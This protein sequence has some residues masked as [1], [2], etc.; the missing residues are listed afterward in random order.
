M[1][2]TAQHIIVFAAVNIAIFVTL[3]FFLSFVNKAMNRKKNK[4]NPN[5]SEINDKKKEQI[6]AHIQKV[7]TEEMKKRQAEIETKVRAEYQSKI[8][9]KDDEIIEIT[10]HLKSEKQAREQLVVEKKKTE[11]V[12]HSIAAGVIVVNDKGETVMMNPAA[13]KILGKNQSE[14]LGKPVI[15][16]KG[17]GQMIS[18]AGSEED[19]KIIL[20]EDEDKTSK[21]LRSS[22]AVIENEKGQ[23]VGMVS[24]ISDKTKQKELEETKTRFVASV[25]H[26]LRTPLTA[27]QRSLEIIV[28]GQLGEVS[29]KQ[30]E[31]L[32]M[33]LSSIQRLR[34]L[35]NDILDFSK[36]DS[37]RME[38][39]CEML[40]VENLAKEVK[41]AFHILVKDKNVKL[42][43]DLDDPEMRIE[44]DFNRLIQVLTNLIANALKYT[45]EGGQITLKV[46]GVKDAQGDVQRVLFEIIDTGCGISQEDQKNIFEQFA[47]GSQ[48]TEE[49]F[50]GTGLGLTIAKQ[51]VELHRG[52]IAVKSELGKGSTFYFEI[53]RHQQTHH[54]EDAA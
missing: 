52:E 35:V 32:G 46:S 28:A 12:I 26:E 47:Q 17:E 3:Y 34:S 37:G 22:S 50:R 25:S 6:Q 43:L 54:E 1:D 15:Q 48:S 11:N 7:L 39:S 38:I 16:T 44:G 21:T 49:K 2:L 23:T 8:K 14:A 41:K 27:I 5:A 31:F 9:E 20:S 45:P 42:V 13:E 51:I 24:I 18:I 19:G 4:L 53:P 33:S 29:E 10:E 40:K 36:L 30:A